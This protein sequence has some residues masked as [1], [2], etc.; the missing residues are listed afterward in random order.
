[1]RRGQAVAEE[2]V[3]IGRRLAGARRASGLSQV[4]VGRR[5][6]VAQSWIAKMEV[7]T[8]RLLFSEAVELA[9]LYRVDLS[10]FAV[11]L[12]LVGARAVTPSEPSD[13]A[14]STKVAG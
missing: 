1:L 12:D 3:A 14:A 10:E 7:G 9:T 4:E 6:G 8:R 5:L 2:D 13:L 11:D